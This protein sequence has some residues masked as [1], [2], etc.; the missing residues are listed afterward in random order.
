MTLI[1][2]QNPHIGTGLDLHEAVQL[3][4]EIEALGQLYAQCPKADK[5]PLHSI[6][7]KAAQ[8]EISALYVKDERTRM[9]LGS[10]KALGAASVIAT[11][12]QDRAK[13]GVFENVLADMT[14]V[15]ASAGNHGYP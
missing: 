5:T 14:F 6:D 15:T 2:I 12:A 3:T 8:I 9:G 4:T 1:N 10:F 13:N 11:I 7:T